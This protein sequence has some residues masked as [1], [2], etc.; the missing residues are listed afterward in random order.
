MF[1]IDVQ[2]FQL[3]DGFPVRSAFDTIQLLNRVS[4]ILFNPFQMNN[5]IYST[6]IKYTVTYSII[7]MKQY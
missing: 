4:N 6:K 3:K 2:G 1:V 5:Y 7:F